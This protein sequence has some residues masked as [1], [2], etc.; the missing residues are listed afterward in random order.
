MNPRIHN[1]LWKQRRYEGINFCRVI[2][3][4]EFFQLILADTFRNHWWNGAEATLIMRAINLKVNRVL[5][6]N[7]SFLRM[8]ENNK[9]T[10]EIDWIT[11]YFILLS[12]F[13]N[14]SL[15]VFFKMVQKERV[16]ISREIQ[17]INQEFLR[18]SKIGVTPTIM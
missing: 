8:T 7:I 14:F 17:I 15:A 13:T 12:V 18:I 1:F 10:E 4:R 5:L 3:S 11:K 16:L 6:N 2:K 9:S